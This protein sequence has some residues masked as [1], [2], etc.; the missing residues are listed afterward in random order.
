MSEGPEPGAGGA[1]P[2]ERQ[3][4]ADLLAGDE[5]AFER[6]LDRH[7]A[8]LLRVARLFIASR[9]IAEEVVQET[10]LAVLEGLCKFE[11]RSSLRTWIFRIL[12]NRAR[13]RARREGRMVPFPAGPGGAD[14]DE[15]A[16]DAERFLANGHWRD[17]PRSFGSETPEALVLR[18]E[19][20][21]TVD[22]AL[23]LLPPAQRAVI[24]VSGLIRSIYS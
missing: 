11:G 12:A 10:W 15:P 7:Q 14:G 19:V 9:A 3:L 22:R 20:R 21:A 8:S 1:A 6:L 24:R 4:V 2:E 13:T 17:P 18:A 23:E 16:V 5:A